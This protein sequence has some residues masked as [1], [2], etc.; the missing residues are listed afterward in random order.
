M[1]VIFLRLKMPVKIFPSGFLFQ[2]ADLR[3]P[4]K[5]TRSREK[6]SVLFFAKDKCGQLRH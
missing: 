6:V 2:M 1:S 4:V 5:S 3:I